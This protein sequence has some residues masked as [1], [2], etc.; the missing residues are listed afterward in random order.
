M[1]INDSIKKSTR[2]RHDEYNIAA[3][4]SKLGLENNSVTYS[5]NDLSELTVRRGMSNSDY[6]CKIRIDTSSDYLNEDFSKSSKNL[7]NNYVDRHARWIFPV[8]YL[9]FLTIYAVTVYMLIRE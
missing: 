1:Q 9:M 7:S 3:E 8:I 2:L 4:E 5:R 6:D